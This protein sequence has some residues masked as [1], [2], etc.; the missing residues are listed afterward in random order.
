MNEYRAYMGND[1]HES[2]LGL[3]HSNVYMVTSIMF[4]S[5]WGREC[6]MYPTRHTYRY[7]RV[8]IYEYGA[9]VREDPRE[10]PWER[11]STEFA[12]IFISSFLKNTIQ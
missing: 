7:V 2:Q 8:L 12:Y 9:L 5:H 3:Y 10:K 4:R 1:T 11:I 6:H